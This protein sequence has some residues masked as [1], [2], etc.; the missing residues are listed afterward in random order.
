MGASSRVKFVA[1]TAEAANEFF[2]DFLEKWRIAMDD[3]T[4]FILA[5]HSF[6]GYICAHYAVR[7]PSH[8]KKLMMLSPAGVV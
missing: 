8:I 3:L 1:K 6:G 4:D 2:I 7:Y 5:G